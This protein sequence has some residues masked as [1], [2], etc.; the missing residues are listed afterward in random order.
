MLL[1]ALTGWEQEQDQQRSRA[2]G[3]DHHLVKPVDIRK[4]HDL[5]TG[6]SEPWQ[7][8]GADPIPKR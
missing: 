6:L 1:I 3:F 4:L 2:A 5:L 8:R 7:A